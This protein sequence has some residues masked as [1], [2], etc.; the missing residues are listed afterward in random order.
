M[1]SPHDTPV[2]RT[3]ATSSRPHPSHCDT[4]TVSGSGC[5]LRCLGTAHVPFLKPGRNLTPTVSTIAGLHTI[6]HDWHACV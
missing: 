6:P 1:Q 5:V 2:L 4:Q 3:S